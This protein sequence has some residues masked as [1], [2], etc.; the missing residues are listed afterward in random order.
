MDKINNQ[1]ILLNLY[2]ESL[3]DNNQKEV[4][5]IEEIIKTIYQLSKNQSNNT[6]NFQILLIVN[7]LKEYTLTY[8]QKLILKEIEGNLL[9]T[10]LSYSEFVDNK[11]EEEEQYI[12]EKDETQEIQA[13]INKEYANCYPNDDDLK[14]TKEELADFFL[15]K[16][17][18]FT[19]QKNNS[20]ES[21]DNGSLLYRDN[22]TFSPR[23]YTMEFR[24]N[25]DGKVLGYHKP[26]ERELSQEDINELYDGMIGKILD[27]QKI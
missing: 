20:N 25:Q 8:F 2:I 26:P 9:E 7:I 16:N 19:I 12:I 14:M 23:S 22:R 27:Y 21:Y 17:I 4:N 5:N 3:F 11:N 24:I 18:Q 6:I 13:I 10:A 15:K 1:E